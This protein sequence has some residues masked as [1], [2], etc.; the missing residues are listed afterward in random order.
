LKRSL[1][2]HTLAFC[3][4]A[5]AI[6]PAREPLAPSM[7]RMINWLTSFE[8]AHSQ[9]RK[10][11][12]PTASTP[13]LMST[14]RLLARS[15][16]HLRWRQSRSQELRPTT[17]NHQTASVLEDRHPRRSQGRLLYQCVSLPEGCTSKK[18][19]HLVLLSHDYTSLSFGKTGLRKQPPHAWEAEEVTRVGEARKRSGWWSYILRV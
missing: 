12:K 1:A 19:K 11:A 15:G 13:Q 6:H 17:P 18:S 16:K 14:L 7:Q 10:N 8:C 3:P 9:Q 2:L 5:S 4:T